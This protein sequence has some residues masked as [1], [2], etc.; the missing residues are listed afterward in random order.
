[1]LSISENRRE[2]L[3][4]ER[5]GV[6]VFTLTANMGQKF[7]TAYFAEMTGLKHH[8]AWEMLCKLSRVLP[9][10]QDIDGWYMTKK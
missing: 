7:T 2:T 10:V 9:I 1:M 5:V 3:P 8:S 6:V 4:T